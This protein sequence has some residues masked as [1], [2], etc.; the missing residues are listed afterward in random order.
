MPAPEAPFSVK[1]ALHALAALL[2]LVGG[3]RAQSSADQGEASTPVYAA[4]AEGMVR[5]GFGQVSIQPREPAVLSYGADTPTTAAYDS[6][7]VHALLLEVADL[8]VMLLE[9]DVIGIGRRSAERIRTAVAEKTG[10]DPRHLIVAATH[11]H[12][13]T[14][15]YKDDITRLMARQGAEAAQAALRSAFPAQVGVGETQAREDLNLNRAELDGPVNAA[16][17]VLRVEDRQTGALRGLMYNYGT[18]PTIF[19]EWGQN[20]SQFGPDWPGYVSE[21]VQARKRLDLLYERYA[22]KRAVDASPFV[23]FAQGAGGDQQPR[24]S[25]VTTWRGE[26]RAPKQVFM[27]DLAEEV[28][29]ALEGIPASA[30]AEMAF[31]STPVRLCTQGGET[32]EVLVQALTLNDAAFV[33]VPGELGVALAE[34]LRAASPFEKN[35]LIT[36]A[37]DYIGYIVREPLAREK[38]TYQAKGVRFDPHYGA[39]LMDAG[40]KLLDPDYQPLGPRGPA[41]VSASLSGTVDYDGENVVAVGVKRIPAPPNYAGGFWGRRTVVGPDGRFE[42]D[43][44]AAGTL[45]L[46]AVEADPQQPAPRRMKSGYRDLDTLMYGQPVQMEEGEAVENVRVQLGNQR[47]HT[48]VSSLSLRTETLSVEGQRVRGRLRVEGTP[49]QAIRVSLYPAEL[50]YRKLETLMARPVAWA[51]AGDDGRFEIDE[52]PPGR[53]RLG[54]WLDVNANDLPERGI[55]VITSPQASPVV[56]V[57]GLAT[58]ETARR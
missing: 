37:N 32:R 5:V 11:N 40:L 28:L 26:E 51:A 17:Y 21:Y 43:S 47:T 56:E 14:R 35:V 10:L 15:A 27:E 25:D 46:Y 24:R 7:S 1:T 38:V 30:R 45:Y 31:R 53:Y 9:F 49:E 57:P 12:S 22:H 19:T 4:E 34:R 41:S 18:H 55:D 20:Q 29:R 44:L 36:N 23:M 42:I 3:V 58:G 48:D 54:A 6:V 16:L 13:Y 52:V 50:R 2:L 33:T 39:Q 8:Q